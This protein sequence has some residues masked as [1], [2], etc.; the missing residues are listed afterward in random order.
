[1]TFCCLHMKN[2]SQNNLFVAMFTYINILLFMQ[3]L[4]LM[5]L[6]FKLRDF[7][8]ETDNLRTFQDKLCV[9]KYRPISH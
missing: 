8:T 9:F 6:L 7:L 2:C 4:L 3:V 5:W 1:M